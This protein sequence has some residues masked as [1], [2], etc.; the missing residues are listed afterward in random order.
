VLSNGNADEKKEK[1]G[2]V[3]ILLPLQRFGPLLNDFDRFALTVAVGKE[4]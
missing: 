2:I 1:V 4:R 3:A